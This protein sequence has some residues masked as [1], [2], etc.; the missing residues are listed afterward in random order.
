[1]KYSIEV[2][3][4]NPVAM[5][6]CL[7]RLEQAIPDFEYDWNLYINAGGIDYGTYMNIDTEQ[8]RVTLC[9]QPDGDGE[10]SLD[11]VIDEVTESLDED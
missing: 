2:D 11:D 10:D 5:L 9:N 4:R 1:M 7:Q 3:R 8:R 6:H